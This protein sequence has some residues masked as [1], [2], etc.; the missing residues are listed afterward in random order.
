MNTVQEYFLGTATPKGFHTDFGTVIGRPDYYTYILKGGPGTGKSTLMKKTAEHFKD[1]PLSLYRCSSDI[2]SLDAVVIEDKKII[3]VDGTSPHVFDPIYPGV[4]QEIVNLGNF[5]DKKYLSKHGKAIK[6]LSDENQKY[7]KT[8]RRYIEAIASINSDIYRHAENSFDLPKLSAYIERFAKKLLPK[9]TSDEKG[10]LEFCQLSAITTEKYMTLPVSF[11]YSGYFIKDDLFAGG[12]FFLRKLADIFT[13]NGYDVLVSKCHMLH[14]EIYEHL[15][16]KSLGLVF[17]TGNF[18]N[19]HVPKGD[20]IINFAR[21]YNKEKLANKKHRISFN[22]NAVTEL[23]DEA[24]LCLKTALDIHDELE[25]YYINS[26]DLEELS[27]MTE[28]FIKKLE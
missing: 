16:C 14:E 19:T 23:V 13:D 2:N 5:W 3:I 24:A 4:S 6:H 8:T 21:F 27:K 10:K 28:E 25:K 15:I 9:K 20:N 17:T 7:H 26:L 11:D 12:D 18:L 22:K 1:S